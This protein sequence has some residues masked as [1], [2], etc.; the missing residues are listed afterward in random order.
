MTLNNTNLEAA[1]DVAAGKWKQVK[2]AVREQWGQ[3][4]N[5]DVT[6][7][8]GKRDQFVGLLQE[9][10]GYTKQQAQQ[11]LDE[12]VNNYRSF[13]ESKEKEAEALV[14]DN[15]DSTTSSKK[16][17]ALVVTAVVAGV[18]YLVFGRKND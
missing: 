16:G 12:F 5:D 8:Q 1:Q 18:L 2:G 17:V 6:R 15:A 4:T 7:L 10:Y 3:L 9:R 13:K 14:Q 11:S